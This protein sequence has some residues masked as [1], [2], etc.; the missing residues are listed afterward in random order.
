MVM[1]KDFGPLLKLAA[2][3]TALEQQRK[4]AEHKA[5]LGRKAGR[6]QSCRLCQMHWCRVGDW[7]SSS[8]LQLNCIHAPWATGWLVHRPCPMVSTVEQHA[9]GCRATMHH[10][11]YS[12]CTRTA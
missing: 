4:A 2:T 5:A 8:N 7:D 3:A 1:V 9:A 10:A 11:W 6:S 12:G